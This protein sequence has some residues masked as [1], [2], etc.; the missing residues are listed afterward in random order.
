MGL[1]SDG[2]G[3]W[4]DKNGEFVAKTEKVNSSFSISVRELESKILRRVIR[5]RNSL[6]LHMRKNQQHKRL[7]VRHLP[8]RNLQWFPLKL[9]RQRE[10]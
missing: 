3:G 1:K 6:R 10:L 4:Y 5:R 9:K 7:V 8:Q 2:H